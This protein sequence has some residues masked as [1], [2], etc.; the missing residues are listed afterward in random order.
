MK[1]Y[2]IKQTI[3]QALTIIFSAT[4]IAVAI[5]GLRHDGLNIID[6]ES[7]HYTVETD[8]KKISMDELVEKSN[9]PAVLFIDAR[10][11]TEFISGHIKNAKSLPYNAFDDWVEDFITTVDPETEIITYCSGPLCSQAV[12]VAEMLLGMGYE[13]ISYFP[14]GMQA[15]MENKLPLEK[16]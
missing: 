13:N 14:G 8:L 9:D 6:P 10:P 2:T 3:Y 15:W 1:Y 7:E 16:E 4:V 12:E 11:E 5:N